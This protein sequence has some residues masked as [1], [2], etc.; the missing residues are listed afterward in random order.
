MNENTIRNVLRS[1]AR[2]RELITNRAFQLYQERDPAEGGSDQDW[3]RAEE[4]IINELT[5]KLLE[6]QAESWQNVVAQQP[7]LQAAHYFASLLGYILANNGEPT[8]ADL[9]DSRYYT[10][11]LSYIT[12]MFQIGQT[13]DADLFL[14]LFSNDGAVVKALR[15][16]L[17]RDSSSPYYQPDN[18]PVT[19]VSE[20][21]LPNYLEYAEEQVRNFFELFKQML[22]KQSMATT[23]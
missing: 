13:I 4:E 19:E 21:Q 23:A 1:D 12:G 18:Q 20:A 14:R 11:G 22:M 15:Y 8:H 7:G 2:V 9:Y 16:H 6:A 10:I 5:E 3:W 17:H